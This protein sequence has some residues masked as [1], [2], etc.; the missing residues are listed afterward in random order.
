MRSLHIFVSYFISN[1]I[2]KFS[3]ELETI[4]R[5]HMLQCVDDFFSTRVFLVAKLNSTFVINFL[6]ILFK[7][8]WWGR[9]EQQ[10]Y[11]KT[12]KDKVRKC[13]LM[14][15]YFILTFSQSSFICVKSLTVVPHK[16]A[17][18]STRTTLPL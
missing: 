16:D 8:D 14:T 6:E 17:V 1:L 9:Q 13:R 5:S 12:I 15:K 7:P 2:K 10:V 3:L 11:Q 18:F 4:A